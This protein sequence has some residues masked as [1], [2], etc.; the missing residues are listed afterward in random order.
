MSE[1]SP[2]LAGNDGPSA[3]RT[4]RFVGLGAGVLFALF[5]FSSR[6]LRRNESVTYL[7]SPPA[8]SASLA[9]SS[10][11]E[12][13][14]SFWVSQEQ[15]ANTT[16]VAAW[17]NAQNVTLG[18][19]QIDKYIPT[20]LQLSVDRSLMSGEIGE[21]AAGGY[22]TFGLYN[23]EGFASFVIVM[24]MEGELLSVYPTYK[25]GYGAHADSIKLRSPDDVIWMS[26]PENGFN[27]GTAIQWSWR[28][29]V[30]NYMGTQE[31]SNTRT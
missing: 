5:Q 23:G 11:R 14:T 18:S 28:D 10:K 16:E 4:R 22:V 17:L 6:S 25:L 30:T 24:T 3:S 13:K 21:D 29:G 7:P 15:F 12:S 8:S 27:V 20:A 19:E 1:R 2:L 31:N 26:N 9:A